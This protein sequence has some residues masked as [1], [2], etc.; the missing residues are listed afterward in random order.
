MYKTVSIYLGTLNAPL[1]VFLSSSAQAP[2]DHRGLGAEA[3]AQDVTIE[4]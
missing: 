3:E 2:E 4:L 1:S